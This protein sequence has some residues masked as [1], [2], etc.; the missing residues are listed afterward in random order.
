MTASQFSDIGL[1]FKRLRE[2]DG[3]T[4]IFSI[5]FL[6][7]INISVIRVDKLTPGSVSSEKAA[8]RFEGSSEVAVVAFMFLFD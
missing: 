6:R 4:T 5:S 7:S 8:K 3:I 1:R 2:R